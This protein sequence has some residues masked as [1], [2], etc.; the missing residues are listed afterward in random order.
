M[1]IAHLILAHKNP[2]QLARLLKAMEHPGFDFYI[3]IDQKTDA[4]PFAYLF[5][6]RNVFPIQNRTK[7]Y[8]AGYGTIQACVNGFEEILTKDYD[9]VNVMSA[10]D[11]PVKSAS[12][13]YQYIE[14]RKGKEFITCRSVVDEWTEAL[15]RVTRYHFINFRFPGRHKIEAVA[16]RILPARKYPLPHTIVGR[17]NWFTV[18]AGA[19][20]YLL[21]F[22]NNRPEVVR[23]FKFSWG[24]DEIIF[25]T[26]L[27]NSPFKDAIVD[28]LTYVDWDSPDK[29][30]PKILTIDDLPNLK[31]TDKLLARKFDADIDSNVLNLLE[32]W[33]TSAQPYSKQSL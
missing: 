25:S 17:A 11:F 22:I 8:W 3:H 12:Y 7:I 32:N 23:F 19:A 5:N 2:Q 15:P 4:A 14:G 13:I 20:T 31:A 6:N 28:N 29:G 9:Y 10:Q 1:K 24:A 27:Y 33:I 26:I 21:D 18:T 30:H 16:N